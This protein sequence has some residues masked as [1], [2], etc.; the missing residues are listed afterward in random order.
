MHAVRIRF[1]QEF[2]IKAEI[3]KEEVVIDYSVDCFI[4]LLF[5]HKKKYCQIIFSLKKSK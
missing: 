3:L 2:V 1:R 5:N 4:V